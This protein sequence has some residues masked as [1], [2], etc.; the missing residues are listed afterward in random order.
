[1]KFACSVNALIK[2]HAFTSVLDRLRQHKLSV[3]PTKC[4]WAETEMDFLGHSVS[5]AGLSVHPEQTKA[6]QDW[7][8]PY[9][10]HE[11]LSCLGTFNYW[12]QYIRQIADIVVPLVAFD[13]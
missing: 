5:A 1:M 9:N 10:L 2:C 7:P 12:R 4:M 13:T 3:K 6:L 11:L 8:T